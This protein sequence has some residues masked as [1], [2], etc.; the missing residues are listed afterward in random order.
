[1][2]A[3]RVTRAVNIADV[4]ILVL[5][6]LEVLVL[7]QRLGY[8]SRPHQRNL[9]TNTRESIDR[10]LTIGAGFKAEL[11]APK[12]YPLLFILLQ[13][14]KKILCFRLPPVPK[15]TSVPIIFIGPLKNIF[16]YL[17]VKNNFLLGVAF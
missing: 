16:S 2:F 3:V 5:F 11:N 1:L 15:K 12:P 4:G 8:D 17:H 7:R 6:L 10:V 13:G 9:N 14:L